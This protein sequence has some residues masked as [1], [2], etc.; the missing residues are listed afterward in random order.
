MN[1]KASQIVQGLRSTWL[2]GHPGF[3]GAALQRE[4]FY[5]RNACEV[6]LPDLGIQ[7]YAWTRKKVK[8]QEFCD[9]MKLL[10]NFIRTS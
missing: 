6:H 9:L 5:I 10:Y 1:R 4:A 3:H 2:D 8:N 7:L